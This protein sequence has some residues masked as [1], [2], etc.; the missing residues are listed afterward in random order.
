MR[1]ETCLK[2]LLVLALFLSILLS[3]SG[4]SIEEKMTTG[5]LLITVDD[6]DCDTPGCFGGPEGLTPDIDRL[7]DEGIRFERAHITLVICQVSRQSLMTGRFRPYPSG[8]G[9]RT[10]SDE[11]SMVRADF[12]SQLRP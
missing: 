4:G 6:M 12:P 8:R 11:Q 7:A 5:I 9:I 3:V 2:T 1:E 10:D